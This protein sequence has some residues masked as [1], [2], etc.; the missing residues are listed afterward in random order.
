MASSGG[1]QRMGGA[2]T[3]G[4]RIRGATPLA[5]ALVGAATYAV[6]YAVTFTVASLDPGLRAFLGGVVWSKA[7]VVGWLFYG[8]HVVPVEEK[9]AP[10]DAA[11]PPRQHPLESIYLASPEHVLSGNF[12]V[13]TTE[14]VVPAVVYVALPAAALATAG[15]LLG[16]WSA[17]RGGP[18]ARRAVLRSSSGTSRRWSP[19]RTPSRARSSWGRPRSW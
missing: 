12:I 2:V 6:A 1:Q 16:S 7:D 8:A 14:L 15:Y 19:A 11:A 4:A 5:G 13:T 17:R 18:G 9:S 10:V 3:A